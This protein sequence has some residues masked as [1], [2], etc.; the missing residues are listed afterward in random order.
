MAARACFPRPFP[1]QILTPKRLFESGKCGIT[2]VKK[3]FVNFQSVKESIPFLESMFLNCSTF[4]GTRKNH[5]FIPGGENIVMNCESR[6]A[7]KNLFILQKKVVL[8][9]EH[10][11]PGS[12]YAHSY[13]E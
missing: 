11:V 7:S 1:E 12:F 5:E 3:Y 9:I 10:M 2:G 13:D 4:K 6:G 8:S